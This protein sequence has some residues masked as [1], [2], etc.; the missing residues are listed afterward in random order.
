MCVSV[1]VYGGSSK[2]LTRLI[3]PGINFVVGNILKTASGVLLQNVFVCRKC[4]NAV[5]N[6]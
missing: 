6:R 5:I 4:E 1:H 2:V 3:K